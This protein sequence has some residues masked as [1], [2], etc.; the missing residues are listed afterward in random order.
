MSPETSLMDRLKIF[1][2]FSP[3]SLDAIKSESEHNSALK[4]DCEN[5]KSSRAEE[6]G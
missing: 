5:F 1:H 2:G 6:D 4:Q 3:E